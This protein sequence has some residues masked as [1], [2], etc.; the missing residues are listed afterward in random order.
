MVAISLVSVWFWF[1]IF[2]K[3]A[4]LV[5]IVQ[6]YTQIA[7]P[8]SGPALS[9]THSAELWCASGSGS[10][11]QMVLWVSVSRRN[12]NLSGNQPRPWRWTDTWS[13]FLQSKYVFLGKVFGALERYTTV[14]RC[15]YL[16][17]H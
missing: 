10:R 17:V 1:V 13:Y 15:F 2:L 7:V 16:I 11:E 4:S 3:M 12:W 9:V 14:I 6:R 8:S 5:G